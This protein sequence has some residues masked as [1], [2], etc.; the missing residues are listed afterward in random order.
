[1]CQLL[2][3]LEKIDVDYTHYRTLGVYFHE[4][5]VGRPWTVAEV[6]DGTIHSLALLVALFDPRSTMLML[7]EPEN[8]G[9]VTLR[10]GSISCILAIRDVTLNQRH[11][12]ADKDLLKQRDAV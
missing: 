10:P 4:R 9:P 7:E 8:S 11:R 5:S 2:P 3:G 6:S 1:M 12:V